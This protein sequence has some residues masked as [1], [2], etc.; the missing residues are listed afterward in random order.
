MKKIYIIACTKSLPLNLRD[1]KN[2]MVKYYLKE[3]S[4]IRKQ[5]K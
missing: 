3:L 2:N 1:I 5:S 4:H